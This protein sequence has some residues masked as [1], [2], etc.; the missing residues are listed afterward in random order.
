M[1]DLGENLKRNKGFTLIELMIVVAIIGI[2]SMLALPAYQDY[3]KRTYVAEGLALAGIA[4]LA[5]IETFAATG[6]WPI[7]NTDAGLPPLHQITGQSVSA[8]GV[9][10]NADIPGL[11]A[12]SGSALSA[13]LIY[14]NHKVIGQPTTPPVN[15]TELSNTVVIVPQLTGD[16]SQYG[17]YEWK[18]VRYDKQNID[19]QW[20]PTACRNDI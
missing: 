20:L 10:N 5:I 6:T 18:C 9:A 14:Y 7:S 19:M 4:K 13:I 11:S 17:S 1:M 3:T 16:V 12:F 2:L 15:T 8:I